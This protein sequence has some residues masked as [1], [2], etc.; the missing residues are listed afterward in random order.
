MKTKLFSL[1]LL[2]SLLFSAVTAVHASSAEQSSFYDVISSCDNALEQIP[3]PY[4]L[5]GSAPE[6]EKLYLSPSD[7]WQYEADMFRIL[8]EKIIAAVKKGE[9]SIDISEYNIYPDR[10]NLNA[11]TYFSPYISNGID[12][13]CWYY[14][15]S[16]YQTIDIICPMSQSEVSKYYAEVDAKVSKVASLTAECGT[17]IEKVLFLHDYF[18]YNGEYDYDNLLSGTV[19]A[20]SY[21]SAGILMNGKGVCQS[22]SYAMKYFLHREGIECHIVS[23]DAM[24][25]AWNIVK[26]GSSYYHIDAT[27]DDPVRDQLGKVIHSHFLLSDS[28][29]S[30]NRGE[31]DNNHYGW[32]RTDLVCNST[33]YDSAFWEKA[34]SFIYST[35]DSYYF[36]KDATIVRRD[37][38]SGIETELKKFD[39]WPTAD[40]GGYWVGSFTGLWMDGTRLYYNSADSIRFLDIATSE[41]TAIYS[42][43]L[44][45]KKIF[46][47]AVYD[48]IVYY[49]LKEGP[50]K[51]VT[52]GSVKLSDIT[53]NETVNII[54]DQFIMNVGS[55]IK[56]DVISSNGSSSLT[57]D[58]SDM[59][60]ATVEPDGTVTA[61][62]TGSTYI[63][64]TTESGATDRCLITVLPEDE[65]IDPDDPSNK[66]DTS[67]IFKDVKK[68]SW[69][70]SA[71]DF[72]VE[73]GLMNGTSVN[74]FEPNAS[75]NRAM[76]VTVLWRLEG[77]PAPEESTPFKD[78]KQAWYR[79]AVAWAYS[80]EIVNGTTETTFSP[81]SSITREQMAAILFRYSSYKGY[82]TD[83]RADVMSYPDGIRISPYA[84]VAMSW[85]NGSALITGKPKGD[86]II[87]A[88]KGKATRA[89]VATIL[90]RY[91]NTLE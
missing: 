37:A 47:S 45:G 14:T 90:Q 9:Q 72:A 7:D 12:I 82:N 71:V 50:R 48:G 59:L 24:N 38:E 91:L 27:W 39:R 18:I 4:A 58:V 64:V 10:I 6:K 26:V 81:G 76:L 49:H 75:M 68:S 20:D 21:R 56:L 88:P 33:V 15:G 53:D 29:I 8:E 60:V 41:D 79:D 28:A 23:S 73:R 30:T 63:I 89:E 44:D 36:I 65:P 54:R 11:L 46:G 84:M 69:F 55:S 1:L 35:D 2:A 87:L 83:A 5:Q 77:S 25:H 3:E 80:R 78:L 86:D 32:D 22:Y 31:S 57:W 66:V 17:D 42:P 16:C 85:A 13:S 40:G 43:E 74:K 67:T 34:E 62:G 70:K 51:E 19:P 52:V 61:I